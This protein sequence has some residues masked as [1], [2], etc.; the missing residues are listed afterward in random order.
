MTSIRVVAAVVRRGD[1]LLVGRRPESKRHGGMWEFPGGKI[2]PGETPADAA[3]RELAE[4]LELT[5]TAVGD[6][7]H[8]VQDG[9]SP[10]VIEFYPVEVADHEPVPHE[11]S[12][13]AWLTVDE[14]AGI[15][16]APAD[17]AF[18]AWLETGR[19]D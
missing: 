15:P 16:L 6:V 12:E 5:V 13:I 7:L 3:R 19:M 10:F 8:E 4:E 1:T 14:L 9:S 11:H 18:V 2:D 17:E